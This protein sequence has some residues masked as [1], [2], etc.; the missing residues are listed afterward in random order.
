MS[1]FSAGAL[2]PTEKSLSPMTVA[3]SAST[4]GTTHRRTGQ[5]G[6]A[7]ERVRERHAVKLGGLSRAA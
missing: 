1:E 6:A 5:E 4:G 7:L 3:R 2:R